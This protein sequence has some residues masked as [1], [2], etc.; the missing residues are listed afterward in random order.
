[1]KLRAQRPPS[2]LIPAITALGI[3]TSACREA[4]PPAKAAPLSSVPVK[5]SR[6]ALSTQAVEDQVVGTVR[7]RLRA[8]LE[9]KVAGRIRAMPVAVG[10]SVKAG[11]L[12]AA[13]D[14]QEIEAKLAQARALS[15]QARS[16]L[17]RYETLLESRAIALQEVEAA[18]TRHEVA[19]AAM[20]E[21]KSMLAYAEVRAPF[22]GVVTHKL[23]E[24]GDLASP[25][26]P[27]VDLEDPRVLR[28]EVA[29]P[30]SLIGV[31]DMGTRIPVQIGERRDLEAAVAELAP[32]ADPNSRTFLVKLDLPERADLRPGQF[33]RAFVPSRATEIIRLPAGAVVTRGQLEL[34]FVVREGTANLRLVRT[35]KR[36]GDEVEVVSG[37]EPSEVIV[38]AGAA[39]LRDG[40]PVEVVQ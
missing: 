33:G 19:V 31:L 25:G 6:V 23:A 11:Q 35:G 4:K 34:V 16:D 26:R 1:M 9:A 29:V 38:V 30:E 37:L 10:D 40:Q 27:L 39:Q 3:T 13:L 21:A 18:R 15:T 20:N 36:F 7:A 32:S 2:W 17:A 24:V 12:V 8:T 28:L 14:V 22:D 5:T